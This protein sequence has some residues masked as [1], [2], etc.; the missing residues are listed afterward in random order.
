MTTIKAETAH[1]A[2][3]INGEG[4]QEVIRQYLILARDPAICSRD[5]DDY[6]QEYR[7]LEE[8]AHKTD[9]PEIEIGAYVTKSEQ[10][11]FIML[12]RDK[13]FDA[14]TIDNNN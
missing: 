10:P 4:R 3:Y 5:L 2:Y 8:N 7:E 14:E 9:F 13:H 1:G 11:E 6:C 12:R